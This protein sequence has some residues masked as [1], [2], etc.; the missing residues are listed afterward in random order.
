M[1]VHALDN[2]DQCCPHPCLLDQTQSL[3]MFL[4]SEGYCV[5]KSGNSFLHQGTVFDL[6]IHR[7][8]VRPGDQEIKSGI[9]TKLDLGLECVIPSK[10]LDVPFSQGFSPDPIGVLGID[11]N[12]E[13]FHEVCNNV[14]TN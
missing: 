10:L 3:D 5:R 9:R 8:L 14:Y 13:I 7:L 6:N 2:E 12:S 1:C 11:S 4:S